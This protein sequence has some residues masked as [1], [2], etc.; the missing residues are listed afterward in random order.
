MFSV[1]KVDD[2]DLV[3]A[4]SLASWGALFHDFIY[5]DLIARAVLTGSLIALA[6]AIFGYP[7]ALAIWRLGQVAQSVMLMILLT[8]LYT[9]ELVRLYA[10]R[11]VLGAEGVVNSLLIWTGIVA[12][13]VKVLLFSPFADDLVLFYN[14]LPFMVL[15]LWTSLELLDRH[16]VDAARDLGARPVQVFGRI[17]L[18]MTM[19]GLTAGAIICFA[20]SS[21]DLLTPQIIGGTS[22]ATVMTLINGLFGIAFDWP[23]ASVVTL[24]FILALLG[25]IV[26]V[27]LSTFRARGSRAVLQGI[28]K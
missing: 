1:Y 11:L 22:G 28:W 24:T 27:A 6:T 20:L 4:F 3:P 10:W 13:P 18:P 15:C 7:I 2:M 5:F 17:V 25:V 12:T 8:P 21:G 9:G 23:M 26:A 16:L 14:N 19:P